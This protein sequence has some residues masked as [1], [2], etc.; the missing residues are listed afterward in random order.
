MP[1]KFRKLKEYSNLGKDSVT[2][3][4]LMDRTCEFWFDGKIYKPSGYYNGSYDFLLEYYVVGIVPMYRIEDN[5]IIP[6]MHITLRK[7][8]ENE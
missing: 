7:E 1:N 3:L 8:I 6:Y 4:N 5:T 2:I